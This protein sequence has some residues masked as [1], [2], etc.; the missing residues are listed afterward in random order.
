MLLGIGGQPLAW[1]RVYDAEIMTPI[2]S[3]ALRF[4]EL[5]MRKLGLAFRALIFALLLLPSAARAS[6]CCVS[7]SVAGNGRLV[8]WENAAAGLTTSLSLGTGRFDVLGKFRPFGTDVREDELRVEAWAIARLTEHLELNARVP[9]VTGFR[10]A[11]DGLN[12]VGT[13]IGDVS[14][15]V[16]WDVLPLAEREWFP[17]I[18]LV[19]QVVGPTGRRPELATDVLGASA[20]GRG[21]FQVSLGAIAEIL[22]L[23]WFI[24]LD[25]A[26]VVSAPFVRADTLQL[27]TFGPGFQVGLAGGRELFGDRLTLALA[28]RLEH[29]L[30][31]WLDGVSVAQS[32]STGLSSALS[33]SFKLTPHWILTSALSTDALGR[34]G[35]SHNR[36]DRVA[37]NLGVRHG[38]F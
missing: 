10:S 35:L 1:G 19:A 6:A 28:L 8:P 30:P 31:F 16:R 32:S 20:T 34:L 37:F 17:G 4:C 38:F 14:A 23:P 36:P 22:E 9:W 29:E 2:V 5:F 15:G 27:Q 33:A 26:G 24:R 21:A 13:G 7:A 25:A 12:T 11:G 18:A 3:A